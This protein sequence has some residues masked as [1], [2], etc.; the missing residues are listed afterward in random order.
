MRGEEEREEA[1]E[2]SGREM[3]FASSLFFF[4]LVEGW[5]E[6]KTDGREKRGESWGRG[7]E[8]LIWRNK[9]LLWHLATRK[10]KGG[11]FFRLLLL[12]FR[13]PHSS[14][15]LVGSRR[16]GEAQKKAERGRKW[17]PGQF[18]RRHFFVTPLPKRRKCLFV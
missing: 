1:E 7:G 14:S 9:Q 13:L 3:F 15:S 18:L 4:R 17:L 12:L 8:T 10:R 16:V 2:K 6:K 5:Y 11:L